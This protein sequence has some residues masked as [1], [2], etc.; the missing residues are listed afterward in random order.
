MGAVFYPGTILKYLSVP[1][2]E[3]YTSIQIDDI[4][5]VKWKLYIAAIYLFFSRH[6]SDITIGDIASQ[7]T[8]VSI[9]YSTVSSGVH[10]KIKAPRHWPLWGEFTGDRWISR[11]KGQ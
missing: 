9:V 10:K 5:T 4:F 11:T 8:S 1:E 6:Y 2:I 3:Q 7:I